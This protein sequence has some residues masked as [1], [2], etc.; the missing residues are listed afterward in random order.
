MVSNI[1]L[2]PDSQH[3]TSLHVADD[4]HRISLDIARRNHPFR[5]T[6]DYSGEVQ[7]QFGRHSIP[8][9][10]RAD[11]GWAYQALVEGAQTTG[12]E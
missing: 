4:Q 3:C 5:P 9:T 7:C 10:R 12:L 2:P 8:G 6:V 1:G 11:P